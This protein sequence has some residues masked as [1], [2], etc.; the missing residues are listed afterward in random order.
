[1]TEVPAGSRPVLLGITDTVYNHI[2]DSRSLTHATASSSRVDKCGLVTTTTFSF[3]T[4]SPIFII[5]ATFF[6]RSADVSAPQPLPQY[7]QLLQLDAD[8]AALAQ[9]SLSRFTVIICSNVI[10]YASYSTQ[11]TQVA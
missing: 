5:A 2:F 3:L 10:S 1:M 8:A 6:A 11:Y 9:G 4:S 7:A